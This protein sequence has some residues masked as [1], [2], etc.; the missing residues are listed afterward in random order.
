MDI[1]KSLFPFSFKVKE[2]DTNALVISI[3]IYVVLMVLSG[4]AMTL[5]GLIPVVNLLV[6]IVGWVLEVY[7]LTGIVLAVLNFLNVLK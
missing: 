1:L 7:C 4:V 6:G 3:I 5:L 2:K